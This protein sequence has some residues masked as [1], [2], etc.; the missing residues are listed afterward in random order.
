MDA[1]SRKR[2]GR[3]YAYV[4]RTTGSR[5]FRSRLWVANRFLG[6]RFK[7][8]V[9]LLNFWATWCG[10]CIAE[11]PRMAQIIWQHF[12][13]NSPVWDACHRART[14]PGRGLEP[15]IKGKGFTF[16]VAVDPNRQIYGLFARQYIPRSY[17]LDR[18]GKILFQSQGYTEAEFA[19]MV[20]T[21]EASLRAGG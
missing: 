3:R 9:V 15:F 7:G 2:K 21:I 8:K 1:N 6:T 19:R 18:N 5:F 11:M 20:K 17:V 4:G 13:G 12:R 14:E 10:P 16:P